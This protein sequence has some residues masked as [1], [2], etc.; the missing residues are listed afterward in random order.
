MPVV[1][2]YRFFDM[3]MAHQTKAQG[4][5]YVATHVLGDKFLKHRKINYKEFLI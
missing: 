4:A 2:R 3:N 1:R 5:F